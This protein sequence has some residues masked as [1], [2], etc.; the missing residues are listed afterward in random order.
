M[1]QRGRIAVCSDVH[2]QHIQLVT[3]QNV[4][5]ASVKAGGIYSNHEAL[6]A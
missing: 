1:L 5:F 4:E 2:T 3:W 6:D